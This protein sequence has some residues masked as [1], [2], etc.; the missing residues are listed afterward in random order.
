MANYM[1]ILKKNDEAAFNGLMGMKGLMV[2]D[3]AIPLKYKLLMGL[4]VDASIGMVDGVASFAKQA[5]AQGVT[6]EELLEAVRVVAYIR[7]V[8]AALHAVEGLADEL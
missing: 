4:V 5:K 1:E 8:S 2:E 7:G 3:G 6:K